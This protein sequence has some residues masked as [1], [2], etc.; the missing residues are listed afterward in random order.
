MSDS[1]PPYGLQHARLLCPSL[2]PRICSNSCPLSWWCYPTI[3]SSAALFSFCLQSFPASG[4]FPMSQLFTLGGQSIEA[5]ASASVLPMNIQYWFPLGWT[6]LI[7]LLSKELSRIRKRKIY[8]YINIYIHDL[9]R[10][11]SRA[12]DGLLLSLEMEKIPTP[13][14]KCKDRV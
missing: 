2:S 3:T 11:S 12:W 4:S 8:M 14:S 1:L 7:Y 6:G 9:W 10:C 13:P 5:S